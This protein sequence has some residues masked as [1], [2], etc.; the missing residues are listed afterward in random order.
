MTT[1]TDDMPEGFVLVDSHDP[2]EMH[3][4]PF[5]GKEVDGTRIYGFRVRPE[6]CNAGGSIHGGVLMTFGDFAVC[7]AAMYGIKGEAPITVSFNAEFTAPADVGDL[8]IARID[9]LRRT[10]SFVFTR[11]ELKVG[12]RVVLGC[13]AVIKRLKLDSRAP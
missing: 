9:I 4:G 13:S 2:F 10:G 8:V 5:Y 6:H 1:T 11:G 12:E 7:S 3:A